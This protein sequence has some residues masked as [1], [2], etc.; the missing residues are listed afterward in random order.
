MTFEIKNAG[1]VDYPEL[2]RLNESCVPNVNSIDETEIAFFNQSARQ[3]IKVVEGDLL[4]GFVIALAPGLA[5]E[6][7]NYQWFDRELDNFLYIDRIMVHPSFRKR[8]VATF[9]YKHLAL[10]AVRDNLARL[11][12]EVNL[13]PPNP[14]SLALHQ[15][16]GF[17]VQAT[18]KTEAGSKEVSL[19]V[20]ELSK[21]GGR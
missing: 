17:V 20:K 5:Y 6:S 10:V 11:C 15:G 14:H 8:G 2:L 21:E 7:L 9:L 3:F 19:M 1:P 4:A 16:L 12:C 13:V 18:Q